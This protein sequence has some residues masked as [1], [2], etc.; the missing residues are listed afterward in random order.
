M[1]PGLQMGAL[2]VWKNK[3][4]DRK[5]TGKTRK[6]MVK[7]KYNL[8]SSFRQTNKQNKKDTVVH[9][10]YLSGRLSPHTLSRS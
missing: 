9:V 2:D 5:M 3:V 7:R 10:L 1:T 6:R 8:C 4:A